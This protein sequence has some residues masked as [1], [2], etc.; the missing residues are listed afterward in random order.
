MKAG[1]LIF[2]LLFPLFTWGANAR[3]QEMGFERDNAIWIATL[4]GKNAK[5]IAE[6]NLPEISPDGTAI[7][8]NTNEEGSSS[9]IRHIAVYDLTA[10]KSTILKNIPSNNCF[11]PAWSPDSKS[12]LFSIYLDQNWQIAFIQKDGTGFRVVKKAEK[13]NNA[14]YMP[15]WAADGKSFFSHDLD[16]IYQFALDGSLLKKWE[17]HKIIVNGDMNSNSRINVSPGGKLLLM[18]IDMGEEHERENW[19]GPP[20]A[21]WVLDFSQDHAIRLTPDNFFAWEPSWINSEEFL[22]MSQ[23]EKE[24]ITSIYRGSLKEKGFQLVLKNGR[25][26]SANH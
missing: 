18:D 8:F 6:G 4:E 7:A 23:G 3:T 25:T 2:L 21:I 5:K 17:I 15:A 16:S 22:F 26:P 14:F 13:K 9:P 1:L 24:E 20:P 19:D 11:G 12:L 10:G